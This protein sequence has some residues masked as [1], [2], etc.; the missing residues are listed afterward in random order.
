M[1]EIEK[2]MQRRAGLIAQAGA[3]FNKARGENREMSGEESAQFDAMHADASELQKEVAALQKAADRARLQGDAEASLRE[4]AGRRSVPGQPGARVSGDAGDRVTW[5]GRDLS[6]RANSAESRRQSHDYRDAFASYLASGAENAVMQVDV[7]DR[8]GYLAPPQYVADLLTELDDMMWIRRLANVRT[9]TTAPSVKFNRRTARVRTFVWGTELSAPVADANASIGQYELAPSPMTGEVEVSNDLLAA[10]GP[11]VD[12][13]VRSEMAW[14]AG[15]V[16]EFAFLYGNGARKPIGLF[17]PSDDG[18]PLSRDVSGAINTPDTFLNAKYSLKESY[19]RS[20][21]LRWLFSR[22]A[23]RDLSKLKDSTGQP[24]WLVSNREGQPDTFCGVPTV[25]S[26]Y[27]PVPANTNG[28]FATG[29]YF[30]MIGD[31]KGYDIQDS[32]EMAIQRLTDSYYARR[33]MT[34][35][36]ARR[37]VDGKVRWP[38]AFARVKLS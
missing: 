8:G 21:A 35:F 26:E 9:P 16:E 22:A 5:R 24:L 28:Q 31:F 36:I 15:D 18:I 38:N 12:S 7:Q 10:S 30:G 23:V 20:T 2:L 11:A 17:F 4:T 19:L 27:A 1:I 29:E 3:I 37:R 34:G 6:M 25:M 14:D 32:L 33:N 13:F